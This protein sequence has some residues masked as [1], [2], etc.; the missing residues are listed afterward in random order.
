MAMIFLAIFMY[1]CDLD[2]C[3]D[4]INL[5]KLDLDNIS[6][7]FVPYTGNEVLTFADQNG[8]RHTL[9]SQRG[10]Q[11]FD[12]RLVLNK[13]CRGNI[14]KLD[15]DDQEEYFQTQR[16]EIV[17]FDQSGN[18][19]FYIDLFTLFEEADQPDAVAIY[20]QLSVHPSLRGLTFASLNVITKVRQ[21][22]L[23]ASY[24]N[25]L[26][27]GSTFIGDTVLFEREFQEVYQSGLFDGR[28]TFYNRTEGVV[29]F[30]FGKGA[31]WVLTD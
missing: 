19:A 20:D 30:D 10:R 15:F 27:N 13:L 23:S 1:A 14:E 4:D 7:D 3:G 22:E 31:Y 5:G 21:N 12:T 16:E 25:V 26:L 2:Q 11:E 28:S 8:N 29:A 9:T 17:F 24:K 18:Q 6:R